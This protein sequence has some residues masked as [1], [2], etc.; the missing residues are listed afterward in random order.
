MHRQRQSG[1]AGRPVDF[2]A[3]PAFVRQSVSVSTPRKLMDAALKAH[4]VP[5]LRTRGFSGSYPHFRRALADRIDLVTVQFDRHGGAFV[6]EMGSCPVDGVT[7]H[8]GKHIPSSKVTA[9]DLHPSQRRRLKPLEAA[10]TDY[11]FRFE[12]GDYDGVA[13]QV[14]ECLTAIAG[15]RDA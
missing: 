3:W 13:T 4:V 7:M 2:T 1:G 11:W 5:F 12:A 9:W 6:V 10:G 8:W 15:V 14:T